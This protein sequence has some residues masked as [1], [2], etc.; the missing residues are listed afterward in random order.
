MGTSGHD[1]PGGC[2]RCG[3]QVIEEGV[4]LGDQ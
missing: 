3:F 2:A 1:G 4:D